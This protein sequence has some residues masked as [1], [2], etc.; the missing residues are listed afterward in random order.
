[1]KDHYSSKLYDYS[2]LVGK[3]LKSTCDP[4]TT[5]IDRIL[6]ERL[7]VGAKNQPKEKEIVY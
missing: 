4:S 3:S 2:E 7:L 5:S 6:I 1:M